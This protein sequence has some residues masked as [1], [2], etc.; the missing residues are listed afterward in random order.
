[1]SFL[2]DVANIPD[3]LMAYNFD[4]MGVRGLKPLSVMSVDIQG[5]S[6][7]VRY[8]LN[9]RDS[10]HEIEGTTKSAELHLYNSR[11]DIA[12]C[13][14]LTDIVYDSFD[15][16]VDSSANTCASVQ[17]HFDCK[18][19]RGNIPVLSASCDGASNKIISVLYECGAL[20]FVPIDATHRG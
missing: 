17:L 2:S 8:L 9:E 12:M 13:I 14:Q 15:L 6:M 16:V 11:G 20:R 3:P 7:K 5:T 19:T 1:M 4:L 18:A 10:L